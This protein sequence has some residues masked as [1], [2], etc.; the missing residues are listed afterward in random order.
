MRLV[1]RKRIADCRRCSVRSLIPNFLI[2]TLELKVPKMACAACVNT[3]TKAIKTVDPAATLEA[4]TQTKI[5]KVE[6]RA[7][8]PTIKEAIARAGYPA[9]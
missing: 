2:M 6:T 7:P 1:L 8:A 3:M 4:D 9:S 5:V